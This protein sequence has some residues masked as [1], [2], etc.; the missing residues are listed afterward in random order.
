MAKHKI[1]TWVEAPK[2]FD[3]SLKIRTY[4][5]DNNLTI[6]RLDKEDVSRDFLDKVMFINRER[7]FFHI[8]GDYKPLSYLKKWL[9]ELVEDSHYED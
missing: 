8:S 2:S 5:H 1:N 3:L 4:C 9:E 6:H 7:V